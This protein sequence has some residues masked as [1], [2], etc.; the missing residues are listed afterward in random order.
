VSFGYLEIFRTRGVN[1]LGGI[2]THAE[3][4][5]AEARLVFARI[6]AK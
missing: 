4:R 6:P 3:G 5:R 1:Y 2:R